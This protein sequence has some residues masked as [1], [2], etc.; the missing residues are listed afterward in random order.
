ME[1]TAIGCLRLWASGIARRS[2]AHV[3]IQ[4]VFTTLEGK[5]NLKGVRP[6]AGNLRSADVVL[7]QR[8]EVSKFWALFSEGLDLR[9]MADGT[10]ARDDF[11]LCGQSSGGM[12]LHAEASDELPASLAG[13]SLC[14]LLSP[15]T[16]FARVGLFLLGQAFS[17]TFS[18]GSLIRCSGLVAP[19]IGLGASLVLF[20]LLRTGQ[21]SAKATCLVC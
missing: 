11:V 16:S 3:V 12:I 9:T 10:V 8:A 4:H 17:L 1:M 20:V 2:G 21:A 13:S 15:T 5:P 18:L 14:L 6:V 19:A 7:F